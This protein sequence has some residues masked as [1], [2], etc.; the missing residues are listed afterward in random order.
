MMLIS[1]ILLLAAPAGIETQSVSGWQIAC[2]N[3]S[4]LEDGLYDR[5]K[6]T[7]SD[8]GLQISV[9]RDFAGA[10]FSVDVKGCKPKTA[11]PPATRTAAQLEGEGAL[12]MFQ[13]GVIENVIMNSKACKK[14]PRLIA[15]NVAEV[16]DVLAATSNLRSK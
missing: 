4:G 7:K 9:V 13:G 11:V 2:E 16:A 8:N 12:K 15:I 3:E 14:P 1:T 5:C 6:M 10:E